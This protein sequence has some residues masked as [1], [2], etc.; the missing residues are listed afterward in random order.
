MDEDGA[1]HRNVM[2]QI[3]EEITSPVWDMLNLRFQQEIGRK[4][5]MWKLEC[6]LVG[7]QGPCLSC[8]S[9]YYPNTYQHGSW[10]MIGTVDTCFLV[11]LL[12]AV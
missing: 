8:S 4:L 2:K 6:K 11:F 12:V 1:I 3:L 10:H 9:S 7:R 5:E